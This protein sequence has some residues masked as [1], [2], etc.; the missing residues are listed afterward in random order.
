VTGLN[1]LGKRVTQRRE[2]KQT[3]AQRENLWLR[4][5]VLCGMFFNLCVFALND[6]PF[7]LDDKS[8]S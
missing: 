3:K 4:K 6:G 2:E 7:D 5:D 1:L 8:W